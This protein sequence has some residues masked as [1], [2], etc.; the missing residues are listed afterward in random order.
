MGLTLSRPD[1]ARGW[2]VHRAAPESLLVAWHDR[3]GVFG[4]AARPGLALFF[5]GPA[6]E[7]IGRF[8]DE[9]NE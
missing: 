3:L 1:A 5:D 4:F 9:A 8:V 7:E 2:T 6:L